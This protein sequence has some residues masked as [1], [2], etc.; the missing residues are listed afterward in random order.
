MNPHESFIVILDFGG[1]YTHLISR[2]IRD[3]GVY[4]EI[5]PFNVG[6]SK[7]KEIPNLKGVILSG[8]PSS[9][10]DPNAPHLDK[11]LL[12]YFINKNIPILGLCY[13]HHMIAQ[14]MGGV[15]KNEDNKEFGK[16][17]L[18][19]IRSESLMEGLQE[20][21]IVWMSHGDQ[22]ES[23]PD[24]YKIYAKT[25][26]CPIA[27]YGSDDKGV[28]GLQFHPEVVH[29]LSGNKILS[30]FLFLICKCKKSWKM[31]DWITKAIKEIQDVVGKESVLLG[32]SG[33]VDSSVTARLLQ[34]AIADRVHPVFVNNGLLRENEEKE[35]ID[36]FQEQLKFKNF[37]YVDASNLFL[38]R[39]VGITDPEEKRKII[40]NTFIEV[41]EEK[42]AELKHQYPN[43]TYLAQGTIYPDRVESSATSIASSKIKSHHNVILPDN[44]LLKLIEPLRDLYKDEVR[45]IGKDLLP[46]YLINRQP[47][48]GP[49]LAVR[50]IGEITK[51]KLAILKKADLIVREEIE[52]IP[53]LQ[54][55]LWQYFAVFLPVKT[56]GVMG[57]ARTYESVCVV[58]AVQSK[59]AM[60]SNFA[61]LDWEL[62]ENI[63]SRIINEVRGINR[64]VYDISNKPP[65]T[66]EF[67]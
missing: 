56:V 51:V 8:G 28:Y 25:V 17:T 67:E 38:E 15:V 64:V 39:L 19:V 40:A 63:S 59:D 11:K 54:D 37:H 43:I 47:F 66:I 53:G 18:S 21:E 32:L 48:P 23:L 49:G 36:T 42:A 60:T 65:S 7:I 34:K 16:T 27:A 20:Q 1:Q 33:G 52:K 14:M 62:L 44:M 30:N 4:S 58:R 29:T 57:D 9:V 35:I 5:R 22:I 61:K 2:R 41:F 3:L 12:E 46:D 31:E 55:T 45:K 10:Y 26:N 24:G 13:G 50:C 6:I